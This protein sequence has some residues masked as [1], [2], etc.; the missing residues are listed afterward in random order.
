VLSHWHSI[1]HI[2]DVLWYVFDD[3]TL[4]ICFCLNVREKS[5]G[6]WIF[7]DWF[8]KLYMISQ[9]ITQLS[10]SYFL[11]IMSADRYIAG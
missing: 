10:T 6:Q 8:C 3:V 11:L 7:G 1:P 4:E 2:H 5:T 9:S